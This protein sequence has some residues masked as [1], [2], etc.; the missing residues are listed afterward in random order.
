MEENGGMNLYGYVKNRPVSDVD[1]LG[2]F[3]IATGIAGAAASGYDG[4]NTAAS[5]G[6]NGWQKAA[7]AAASGLM[8][9]GIGGWTWGYGMSG[10]FGA[11]SSAATDAF[12]QWMICGSID[13]NNVS[14]AARRG[15]AGGIVG[16]AVGSYM[17]ATF[18]GDAVGAAATGAGGLAGAAAGNAMGGPNGCPCHSK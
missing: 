18:F 15:L 6:G 7:S 13:P 5:Y 4:W 8:G 10:A 12:S 9:F 14:D 2:L 17:A 1:S 3:N 11:A 16:A